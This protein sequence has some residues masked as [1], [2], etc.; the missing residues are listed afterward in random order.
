[1]PALKQALAVKLEESPYLSIYGDGRVR[2]GLR[3]MERNADERL[4]PALARDLCRRQGL[5]ATING[6]IAPLGTRYV[7][8]LAAV[9]CEEG[10]TIA[11]AQSEAESK[12]EVLRTL[13]QVAVDLRQRLG[14]SLASIKAYDA[15]IEQATTRS[16][17]ALRAFSLGQ[18]ARDRA[19]ERVAVPL[20]KQAAEIDP[21]FAMAHARLGAAYANM[22]QRPDAR[23]ALIRAYEL[24][25]RASEIERFYI[26]A[27]HAEVVLNDDLKAVEVYSAWQ[28]RYPNDFT[29]YNNLAGIF[30]R[31]SRDDEALAQAQQAVRMN[32][33]VAFPYANLSEVFIRLARY[34]EAR[35][36]VEA[37]LERGFKYPGDL[38]RI[39][40][41]QGDRALIDKGLSLMGEGRQV[42]AARLAHLELEGAGRFREAAAAREEVLAAQRATGTGGGAAEGL[43]GAMVLAI[44]GSPEARPLVAAAITRPTLPPGQRANAS[45]VL[46][47]LGDAAEAR[48]QLDLA[49]AGAPDLREADLIWPARTEAHMALAAGNPDLALTLLQ[50][51]QIYRRARP[52]LLYISGT[53]NLKS[54]RAADAQAEWAR[55]RQISA[56]GFW[57]VMA[58]LGMARSAAMLGDTASAKREYQD[59]LAAWKDADADVPLLIE[60][61]AEYAKLNTP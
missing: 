54:G 30:L 10:D 42:E 14:E 34:D 36:V 24:R 50:K 41:A 13:G 17:E 5:K 55:M 18:A 11:R 43:A 25:G 49:L 21:N 26:E 7:V 19:E 3:L 32:P 58:T 53:A 29:T 9:S 22:G 47:M 16:L 60:A 4:T 39:G 56:G 15:P 6:A 57:D 46:A 20:L 33:D 35:Q 1:M 40:I 45:T 52:P 27:R 8:S 12:E 31:L 2:E 51:A 28:Q 38:V 61:K 44:V 59:F 37:A 48:R 23:A